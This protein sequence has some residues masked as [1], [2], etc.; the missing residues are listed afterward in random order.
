MVIITKGAIH[1]FARKHPG[2]VI[3]LNNWFDKAVNASWKN[4]T[5]VKATF[6][7]TDSIGDDRYVFDIA[8]NNFRL[9]AMI[10][11]NIRTLYIRAI[12][13][14]AEYDTLSKTKKLTGL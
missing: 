3:P 9:I 4:F 12:L 13:T 10:H 5:E 2:A 1:E 14:H 6:N 11:F 8:G 7:T